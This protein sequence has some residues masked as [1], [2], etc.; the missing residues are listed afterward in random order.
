MNDENLNPET[1]FPYTEK[2]EILDGP[3]DIYNDE[4]DEVTHK[5]TKNFDCYNIFEKK[6]M[7]KKR[8]EYLGTGKTKKPTDILV[9]TDGYSFSCTSVFIKGLQVHGHAII[10]GYNSKPGLD[11]SDFDAS[12]S[13]SAVETFD[14]SENSQNLRKL[15]FYSHITFSEG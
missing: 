8:K 4:K 2:D 3:E 9:F 5:R 13:N 6:I 1:C 12:Q 14:C 7:E 11:K 15:G 10:V